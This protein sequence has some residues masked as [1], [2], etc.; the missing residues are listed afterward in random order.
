MDKNSGKIP[1]IQDKIHPKI[2][3]DKILGWTILLNNVIMQLIER[4]WVYM[5]LKKK[6]IFLKIFL[7]Y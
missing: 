3:N 5:N 6:N 1:N 2:V 7:H 4:L